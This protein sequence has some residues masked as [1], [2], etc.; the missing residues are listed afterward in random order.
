MQLRRGVPVIKILASG[1]VTSIGDNPIYQQF[2]DEELKVLVEE[3]TRASRICAAHLHSK[4]SVI[5]AL[6]AGC[7]TLEH[8][9][10]MDDACIAPMKKKDVILIPTRTLIVEAMKT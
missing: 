9:T 6:R 5:A 1:G 7:K 10:Y 4:P 3:A 8:G 2:S